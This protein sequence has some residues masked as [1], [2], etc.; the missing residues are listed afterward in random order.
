MS[1]SNT[2]TDDLCAFSPDEELAFV[3]DNSGVFLFDGNELILLEQVPECA[4]MGRDSIDTL[5]QAQ[6][7]ALEGA[8]L[9]PCSRLS[10]P[11]I[12][13][14][15]VLGSDDEEISLNVQIVRQ[16]TDYTCWAAAMTSM[17]N[18]TRKPLYYFKEDSIIKIYYGNNYNGKDSPSTKNFVTQLN[19][20]GNGTYLTY[21]DN[22]NNARSDIW[23]ALQGKI[24]KDFPHP[25]YGDFKLVSN[26]DKSHAMVIRGM[27]GWE[28]FSV[29]D[30]QVGAYSTGTINRSGNIFSIT[31]S[32]TGNT[33]EL[34]YY[35]YKYKI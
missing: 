7:S 17:L 16:K 10:V 18:Y 14:L 8:F 19:G 27:V 9:S 6:L 20:S 31:L 23:D 34:Q 29:M 28:L 22:V 4:D 33:Y 12:M 2:F 11:D 25:V 24:I 5:G 35:V 15:G 21:V 3:Y 13:S 1:L 32:C 30:P 26:T